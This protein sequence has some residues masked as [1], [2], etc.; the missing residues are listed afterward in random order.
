MLEEQRKA[1]LTERHIFQG[2]CLL[3]D[4]EAEHHATRKMAYL[5][6]TLQAL[7]HLCNKVSRAE[8]LALAQ[9]RL[10]VALD[11]YN[12][13]IHWRRELGQYPINRVLNMLRE[14]GHD[15]KDQDHLAHL[16][17]ETERREQ[18][19]DAIIRACREA[20]L[21]PYESQ[22]FR[23]IIQCLTE[24]V[25]RLQCDLRNLQREVKSEAV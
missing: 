25:E 9:D 20:S 19:F 7:G 1:L 13:F 22:P 16:I 2:R 21:F 24:R 6:V 12:A 5:K 18:I 14:H 17:Y 4:A 11:L 10:S 15:M 3:S 23:Q 8:S